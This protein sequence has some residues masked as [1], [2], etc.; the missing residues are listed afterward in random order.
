MLT[1]YDTDLKTVKERSRS[2]VCINSKDNQHVMSFRRHI[3]TFWGIKEQAHSLGV[4]TLN[5]RYSDYKSTHYL[6]QTQAQ[7]DLERASLIGSCVELNA[8]R[9]G[10]GLFFPGLFH[11]NLR[12]A[13]FR[14]W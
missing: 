10:P 7:W 6:I 5:L 9:F 13:W 4:Q 12:G 11:L 3:I 8:G 1:F 2:R 14:P